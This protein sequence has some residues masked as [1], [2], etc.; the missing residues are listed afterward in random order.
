MFEFTSF[1]KKKKIPN[2]SHWLSS[3]NL[4]ECL[5]LHRSEQSIQ[6]NDYKGCVK[7][8]LSSSCSL[9][10]AWLHKTGVDVTKGNSLFFF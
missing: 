7:T 1:F 4:D 5:L 9:N 3:N 10:M 8:K 6:V 2:T